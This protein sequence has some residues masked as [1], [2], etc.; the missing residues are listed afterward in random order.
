MTELPP[1]PVAAPLHSA[2]PRWPL[3]VLLLLAVVAFYALG[4]HHYFDWNTVRSHL[5]AWSALVHEHFFAVLLAY[6]A[7][8]VAFTALSLP[9]AG[10]AS[11]VGGALFGRWL[12]TAVVSIGS[13]LGAT[14]AFL[15]SRYV[16][17]DWVEQRFGQR[18]QPLRRGIERD[19]AY[20]L[21]TLRLVP[22][23]PFFLINLAMGLTRMRTW[24]YTAV[25]MIGMLPGT[26]L[27]VYAGEALAEVESPEGLLSRQVLFALAL[28]G[29]VPLLI[30][31][32]VR[33]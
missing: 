31:K 30:R 7:I 14:L 22:V 32:L 12:G 15:S 4:L 19:G 1:A 20:Y 9:L 33:S 8:Y 3:A 25:S 17:R 29:V 5:G 16:F 28:L 11:L 26:F 13:T 6:F 2:R 27:Y 10:I 21:F 23:A 24:T 18:L